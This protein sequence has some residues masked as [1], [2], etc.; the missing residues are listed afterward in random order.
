MAKIYPIRAIGPTVPSTYTDKRLKG[1]YNYGLSLFKPTIESWMKWLNEKEDRSVIYVSFGSLSGLS[2]KQMEEVAY[3]LLDSKCNFVWVVRDEEQRKLPQEVT[4][5]LMQKGLIVNWCVQLEVLS[6]RAVGCFL[7]HCGW[8]S[9]LEAIILGVPMVAMPEWGDQTTNAKMIV[10]VWK[11]GVRAKVGGN[12]IVAREEVAARVNEVL[13]GEGSEAIRRNA[14]KW[15]DLAVDAV[16]EGGSSDM[17]IAEFAKE[18]M[19]I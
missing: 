14:L 5:R 13:H 9:T 15:K 8:N 12:G 18:V 7:T 17:N 19:S 16:S 1:N 4:P 6:H 2:E 10:D 11:I 3:G